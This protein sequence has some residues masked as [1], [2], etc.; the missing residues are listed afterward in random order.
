MAAMFS[1]T[2]IWL[3]SLVTLPLPISPTR[4]TEEPI[5]PRRPLTCSKTS[6]GSTHHDGERPGD[7]LGLSTT[8]RSIEHDDP[9]GLGLAAISWLASG[10]MELMS[11]RIVPRLAP[12]R[13]PL[14]PRTAS[15]TCGEIGQH[16]DDDL[17]PGGDVL[18]G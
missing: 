14:A 10:A 2:M 3:A 5:A 7:G 9:F 12:S 4:V 11:T 18:A 6:S 17:A 15:R 8:D 13:T 16:R 1:A